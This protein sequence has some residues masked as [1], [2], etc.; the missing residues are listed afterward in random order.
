MVVS[1]SYHFAVSDVGQLISQS[2]DSFAQIEMT[3]LRMDIKISLI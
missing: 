1:S 3:K 2:D